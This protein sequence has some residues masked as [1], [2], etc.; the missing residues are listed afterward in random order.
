MTADYEPSVGQE[1]KDVVWVPSPGAMVKAMLDLAE[2]TDKDYL[3]DLGSGDGR[4]VIAAAQRG[5]R[6]HGIEYDADLV[7]VSRRR[8]QAAGV[9]GRATFEKQDLFKTDLSRATVITLFL[10]P[11]INLELRPRLLELKP[12][13]RIVSNTFD[14]GDWHPDASVTLT[15]EEDECDS[16]CTAML[17]IVP[18]KAAGRHSLPQG[19]L[20][21]EQQFQ[22]LT[23]VLRAGGAEQKVEGWVTGEEVELYAGGREYRGRV[24]GGKLDLN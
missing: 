22:M 11:S 20:V 1:G 21:L 14:M 2:V 3:I 12:G 18:A 19:E 7:E 17:W 13:T 8:A 6:A 15:D 4:T 9:A 5:A 10:L 16:W 23:G 24:R